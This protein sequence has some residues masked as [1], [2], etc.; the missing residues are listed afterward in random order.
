MSAYLKI[1][2][3]IKKEALNLFQ[4]IHIDSEI[5]IAAFLLF[6]NSPDAETAET[7]KTLLDIERSDQGRNLFF[8]FKVF[9]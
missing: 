6:I 8:S 4:N 3:Q 1:L 5:R 9:F 2:F 7:I